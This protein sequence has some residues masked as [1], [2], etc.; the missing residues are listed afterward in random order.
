MKNAVIREFTTI[1]AIICRVDV[2][3][4]VRNQMQTGIR[5]NRRRLFEKKSE[6]R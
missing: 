6:A 1:T 4:S 5:Q 2:T 3:Y